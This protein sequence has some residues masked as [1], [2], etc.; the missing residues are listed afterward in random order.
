MLHNLFVDIFCRDLIG[1]EHMDVSFETLRKGIIG[2]D[3]NITLQ[4]LLEK[5]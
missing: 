2:S 4:K 5:E 1:V 3:R